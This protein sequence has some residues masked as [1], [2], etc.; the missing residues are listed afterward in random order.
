[1]RKI[2]AFRDGQF[3]E[4]TKNCPSNST[5][6][7]ED[8][9]PPTRHPVDGKIYDSKSAFRF[10]T[11][12]AGCEEVGNEPIRDK[13]PYKNHQAR[14]ERINFLREVTD[15]R[16][17]SKSEFRTSVETFGSLMGKMYGK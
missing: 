10:V 1:M 15:K 11:R 4:L 12:A 7:I 16:Q 13:K 5:A 3:V 8:S 14:Q 17:F 9:M 2:Y 6:V